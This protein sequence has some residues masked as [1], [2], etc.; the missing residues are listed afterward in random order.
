MV[1]LLVQE[2]GEV[3][4]IR[5]QRPRSY[6]GDDTWLCKEVFEH[7][8]LLLPND[9]VEK[10]KDGMACSWRVVPPE[11]AGLTAVSYAAEGRT[12]HDPVRTMIVFMVCVP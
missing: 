4:Q 2:S 9:E 1:A 8:S 7:I 12:Y 11:D 6:L 3:V 10:E 5:S